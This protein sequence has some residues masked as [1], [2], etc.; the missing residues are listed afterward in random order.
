MLAGCVQHVFGEVDADHAP[1]WQGFE[2]IRSEPSRSATGVKNHFVPAKVQAFEDFF[3]PT[4]LWSRQAVV[5]SGIPLADGLLPISQDKL[6]HGLTRI[7]TDV[8]TAV[9][10]PTRENPWLR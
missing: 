1:A 7:S 10:V 2:Q 6:G 4:D 5:N 3:A 8:L 9:S